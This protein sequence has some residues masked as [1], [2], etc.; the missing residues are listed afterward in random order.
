M[1]LGT[2]EEISQAI[3]SGNGGNY[4]SL[5]KLDNES[6]GFIHDGFTN[7]ITG[8]TM[9][10]VLYSTKTGKWSEGTYTLTIPSPG[11]MTEACTDVGEVISPVESYN[12][13]YKDA[14][15]PDI[16]TKPTETPT[17]APSNVPSDG[18]YSTTAETGASMF[19]VVGVKLTVKNGKMSAVITLSGEGYDYLYMGTATDAATHTGNWIKY[20]LS[21]IHI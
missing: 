13:P 2:R 6:Y 17:P 3:K 10:Y 15:A 16:D 8:K 20:S 4:L 14:K 18:I 5:W 12:D 9:S 1:Y 11:E 21:L 7:E 19:K